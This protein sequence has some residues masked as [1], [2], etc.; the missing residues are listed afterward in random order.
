[1]VELLSILPI[2]SI[3]R[4]LPYGGLEIGIGKL[5]DGKDCQV[6]VV[7]RR[8]QPMKARK[9]HPI[10]L[11]GPSHTVLSMLHTLDIQF[12]NELSRLCFYQAGSA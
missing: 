4:F 12:P 10:L 7:H 2:V 3:V 6:V 11:T 9:V 5:V 8:P 1:M